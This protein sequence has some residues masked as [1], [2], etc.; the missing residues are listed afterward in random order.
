M[1]FESIAIELTNKKYFEY[2]YSLVNNKEEAEDLVSELVLIV[3]KKVQYFSIAKEKGY[4]PQA[5]KKCIIN[6]VRDKH[7]RKKTIDPRDIDTS[8]KT[9]PD[10]QK[11][12]LK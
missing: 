3:H 2:A 5:V 12:A 7:R 11:W 10:N 8:T 9:I 1:S 6:L 4:L